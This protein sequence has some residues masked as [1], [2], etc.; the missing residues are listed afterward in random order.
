M[1]G[2][3]R[4]IITPVILVVLIAGAVGQH[5]PK[6]DIVAK[7]LPDG[8]PRKLV[9]L[10]PEQTS[11][12]V[13]ELQSAQKQASGKRLQEVAF[14]LAAFDSDYEKN[15]DFLIHVLRGC[16]TPSIKFGC[17]EDVGAFLIVLYERGHKDVLE[18]MMLLGK[19]IY[20][21]ALAEML[22]SFYSDVLSNH[23]TDFL[24]TIQ[25]FVPKTQ[26]RLCELAGAGDGGGMA[27]KDLQRVRR[28]LKATGDKLALTCLRAVESSNK[29][30]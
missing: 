17:D 8:N 14:L 29:P 12:A 21:A 3:R 25:R 23:P 30:E 16:T 18:P 24:D 19:D 5:R 11:E 26:R 13:K 2:V 9:T 4:F 15:R 28:Q 6:G 20:S 10:S 22:G 1:L 7:L 27:A